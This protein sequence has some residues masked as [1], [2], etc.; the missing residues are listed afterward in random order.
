MQSKG[1]LI[2]F[3]HRFV[4]FSMPKCA[5]QA[6]QQA[7][8]QKVD[9]VLRDPPGVKHCNYRRYD[10]FLRPFVERFSPSPPETLCLFREPV[11]WLHSW[12]RYRQRSY[13]D[14]KPNSTTGISFDRF[15]TMYLDNEGPGSTIGRQSRFVIDKNNQIGVDHLFRYEETCNLTD[16]IAERSGWQVRLDQINV[17]PGNRD[18]I[19]LPAEIRR[20]AEV[21]MARDFEIHASLK[22]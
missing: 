11:D 16:W 7:I 17:S 6:L 3:K 10:K 4:L 15:V 21:E 2:S 1:M 5:S 14:G 19:N 9:M 22:D 18:T 12:W 13:L 8:G 20:R